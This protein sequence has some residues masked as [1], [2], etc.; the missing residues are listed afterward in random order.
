MTTP[1]TQDRAAAPANPG[2]GEPG[3]LYFFALN[4]AVQQLLEYGTAPGWRVVGE[5]DSVRIAR[6]Q[7]PPLFEMRIFPRASW[8]LRI[9]NALRGDAAYRFDRLTA[10]LIR[11]GLP[12]TAISLRG[13]VAGHPYTIAELPAGIALDVF[14]S[15]PGDPLAAA[16]SL[17]LRRQTLRAVGAMVA[18]LHEAGFHHPALDG[19]HIFVEA[20]PGTPVRV[21]LTPAGPTR[22]CGPLSLTAATGDLTVLGRT[23]KPITSVTDRFR[24]LQTYCESRGMRSRTEIL[25]LAEQF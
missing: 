5:T 17:R 21:G 19:E 23:L 4:E 6:T 16:G 18:K 20:R 9:W 2:S 8:P 22:Q 11:S 12:V 14:L 15:N 24:L 10:Q 1:R 25:Q 3:A 7:A 13:R